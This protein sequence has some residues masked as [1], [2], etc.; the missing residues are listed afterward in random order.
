MRIE[1][2]RFE[3]EFRGCPLHNHVLHHEF[4]DDDEPE[5]ECLVNVQDVFEYVEAFVVNFS[6]VDLIEQLGVNEHV[7]YNRQVSFFVVVRIYIFHIFIV[8]AEEPLWEGQKHQTKQSYI[9]RHHE[10]RSPD[11]WGEYLNFLDILLVLLNNRIWV[12][13]SS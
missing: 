2:N 3:E 4:E 8:K 6:A 11:N 5:I 1:R 9:A 13:L 12:V 10:N 7:K